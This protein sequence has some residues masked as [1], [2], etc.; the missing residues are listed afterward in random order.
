[1]IMPH[2]LVDLSAELQL[3]I[4]EGLLHDD[5]SPIE[6]IEEQDG[7]DRRQENAVKI[8]SD[9]MNWSCTSSY[10]RDLLT[11]YIFK[12]IK[13]CNQ[14]KSGASLAALSKSRHN[15]AVKELHFIGSAPGDA[16]REEDAFSDTV[17]IFPKGVDAVLSDLRQFPNLETLSIE[18]AYQF[19]DYEEWEGALDMCAPEETD[20]EV[21]EAEEEI[22]WRALM[23]RTYEALTRNQELHLRGLVFR[24]LGPKRVSSLNSEAF[25][26]FL[27]HLERFSVS[28]HGEDNGAGWMI[29]KHE[30]YCSLM[31][32]LDELFFDHLKSVVDLTVKAPEE[33][34]IGLE[35]MNHIPLAL[36]KEQMPL[37]KSLHL[38]Y[39]FI[40][41]ELRDF[42][43]AHPKT[44]E[45]LS[46]IN[47]YAGIHGLARDGIH[48]R[49]LFD[50]LRAANLERLR[51]LDILP[52]DL[53]LSEG[54]VYPTLV[55]DRE[56]SQE[57]REAHR[58]LEEDPSRRLFGHASLDDKYGMLLQNDEE[59]LLSFQQGKDQT[60]YDLL[61]GKIDANRA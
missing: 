55:Q 44:L 43:I 40:C 9:L 19:D 34:P 51:Q 25:H 50:P 33:G 22:A 14:E 59:N 13:L 57:V 39:I 32:N 37:L 7:H 42:V 36:K 1:M 61:M 35:G 4:I 24:Q 18:F 10:F 56:V 5:E 26:G 49:Q 48:W 11:P 6:K 2:C 41:R 30:Q 27:S 58:I 31:S 52:A 8:Y 38:E 23:A 29:N 20:E 12:S 46:L 21:R 53:P 47:C 28:I 3:K 16:K 15:E 60:S 45:H 17:G 54:E